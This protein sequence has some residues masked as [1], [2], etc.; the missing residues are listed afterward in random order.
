VR[1]DLTED[2]VRDHALPL[3]WADVGVCAVDVTWSGLKL[4]RRLA[5]R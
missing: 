5:P 1:T 2:G 3:G 4:V